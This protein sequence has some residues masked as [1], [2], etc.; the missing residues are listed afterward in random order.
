MI[1]AKISISFPWVSIFKV[2]TSRGR[3]VGIMMNNFNRDL[4]AEQELGKYL[5]R[6]FYPN[7][8]SLK[9]VHRVFTKKDQL[10]G[11]DIMADFKGEEILIDEKGCL[12]KTVQIDTFALEISYKCKGIRK[13]GWLYN[14][15]KRTT[16]YL[17]CWNKRDSDIGIDSVT[18]DDF[19]YVVVMLVSRKKLLDYLQDEYGITEEV[20]SEKIKDILKNN[21]KGRLDYLGENSKSYYFYSKNSEEEPIN[22][23]MQRQELM[24]SGVVESYILV[25]KNG[26]LRD[27]SY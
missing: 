27:P 5:D 26:E 11:I 20:V 9:N 21:K 7:Y 4:R 17:L 19:Y 13:Q 2:F 15:E 23:V 10:E 6:H 16:H 22:I 12:T 25:T 3:Q 14:R 18:A 8:T 24:D 1:Y